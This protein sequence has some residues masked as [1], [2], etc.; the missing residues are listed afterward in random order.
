LTFLLTLVPWLQEKAVMAAASSLPSVPTYE[1]Y[2]PQN[3]PSYFTLE[4]RRFRLGGEGDQQQQ[5]LLHPRTLEFWRDD[6]VVTCL[7]LR[8]QSDGLQ[9]SCVAPYRINATYVLIAQYAP[10]S[11]DVEGMTVVIA[12]PENRVL[13]F[14]LSY[15]KELCAREKSS[16]SPV[17]AEAVPIAAVVFIVI[18][19][20]ICL[21]IMA[22]FTREQ[23]QNR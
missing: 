5:P 9:D 20:C 6:M 10:W 15:N 23:A 16:P 8:Q 3:D 13:G 7:L 4:L 1:L 22:Y 14:L 17:V 12:T 11:C 18:S 2:A 21:V 19:T